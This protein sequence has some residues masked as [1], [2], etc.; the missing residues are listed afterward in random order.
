VRDDDCV[1][2]VEMLT[3]RTLDL[4]ELTSISPTPVARGV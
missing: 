2:I 1:G 4:V 3:E